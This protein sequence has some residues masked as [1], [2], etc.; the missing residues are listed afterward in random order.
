MCVQEF[1]NG[2]SHRLGKISRGYF[3]VEISTFER[4]RLQYA[5]GSVTVTIWNHD[6]YIDYPLYVL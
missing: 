5:E 3:Q 1:G 4:M 2:E 6:A